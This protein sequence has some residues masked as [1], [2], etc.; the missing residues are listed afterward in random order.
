MLHPA[1]RVRTARC[2]TWSGFRHNADKYQRHRIG[3]KSTTHRLTVINSDVNVI[4][5]GVLSFSTTAISWPSRS[6]T[7][8][9]EALCK[10]SLSAED[11]YISVTCRVTVIPPSTSP[12][13]VD[14]GPNCS[15]LPSAGLPAKGVSARLGV[16]CVCGTVP[17]S[18]S[19]GDGKGGCGATRELDGHA[20]R[21]CEVV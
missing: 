11:K 17:G 21:L 10:T 16:T 7:K 20:T 12:E 2:L 13:A 8:R 9:Q 1:G 5:N 18:S 19:L 3:K 15:R 14:E 4:S 6:T